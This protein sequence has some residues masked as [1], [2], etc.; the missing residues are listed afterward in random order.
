M[1]SFHDFSNRSLIS[2]SYFSRKKQKLELSVQNSFC[3]F[4]NIFHLKSFF[5]GKRLFFVE[6][7]YFYFFKLFFIEK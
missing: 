3:F 7:Y 5:F 6:S 1:I 4:F 2:V